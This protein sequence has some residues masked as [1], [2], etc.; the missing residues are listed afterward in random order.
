[1]TTSDCPVADPV[2]AARPR[3][4]RGL[5]RWPFAAVLIAAP[6]CG[7]PIH[8]AQAQPESTDTQYAEKLFQQAKAEMSAGHVAEA[9]ATLQAVWNID[10]GGGTLLALAIC[11][12][13]LGRGATALAE[14]RQARALATEARRDERAHLAEAHAAQ[15]DATVSRL[16]VVTAR[17][18]IPGLSIELDG[19][20]LEPRQWDAAL[21]I[22]AGDHSIRAVAPGHPDWTA[23]VHAE[24]SGGHLQVELPPWNEPTTHIPEPVVPVAPVAPIPSGRSRS[25][26]S[27]VRIAG[28]AVGGVGLVA[29]GVGAFFGVQA[30]QQRNDA[31]S[32]CQGS[33]RCQD[34]SAY[35]RAT[36]LDA[37][38]SSS[39]L[40][41]TIA[42]ATGLTLV[43]TG[44]VLV[45][46]GRP[47][48]ASDAASSAGSIPVSDAPWV[49]R[50]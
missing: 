16:T 27:A 15:L 7:F 49:V 31:L 9:C 43:V 30:I 26:T 13:K 48:P 32:A 28:F 12:E 18:R 36:G 4:P 17:A 14:F 8:G 46:L 34:S 33:T 6:L 38:S 42:V 40:V 39:G 50:F 44:V 3:C 24:A 11:H 22:D 23:S 47:V 1:M 10:H 19:A 2:A 41:S 35:S 25:T 21:P 45:V 37:K 20:R 5:R 29:T